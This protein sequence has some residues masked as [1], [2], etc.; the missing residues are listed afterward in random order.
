MSGTRQTGTLYRRYAEGRLQ[1]ALADTPAV[2]IHGPRQC[3]KTT[4]ALQ[5][6]ERQGYHYL[7]FDDDNRRQAA[8]ADP[9][10]FVRD[11]PERCILDEV[12]RVPGIFTSLKDSIDRHR[13][14]G[15][16]ILAGS[17]NVLLLPKLADSLAG[18]MEII[19]LRPLA[20]CEVAEEAPV[21]LDRLFKGTLTELNAETGGRESGPGRFRRLGASLAELICS[22][23]YPPV[24]VRPAAKRRAAWYRDYIA[25]IIQRDVSDLS[26]INN[27]DIMPRLLELTA[28]QTARLFNAAD[29]AA[30]FAVSRPTIREYLS[31]L[32][33][34]FLIERLQPWHSNR[35]SRLIKTPKLHLADTGLAAVLL[36][37]DRD[38]VLQDRTLLGQLLETWVYQELR[39]EA[40]WQDAEIRF[41]HFRNKDK[42][43]VD[44]ILQQGRRL[45]GIEVKAAAT[46]TSR[47][48]NPLRKLQDACGGQFAAGV[49]FYDGDAVLPFGEHLHA[50][51]LSLLAPAGE[52]V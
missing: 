22:G 24:L 23:G 21:F 37:V 8:S 2:L 36:G 50:V 33:Q 4:L 5:V 1:E 13:Q 9:V 47:D 14:P 40:D 45:A 6:A 43:E 38:T 17:A 3:G 49:V 19:R 16:F 15:R 20:R 10:G 42:V 41:Y 35:L 11:L 52:S 30:P 25:T 39:K 31:L 48:F 26:R 44:M 28:G 32:E 12:Q 29:L 51:P 7:S 46:V 34:I 27:L 18:R